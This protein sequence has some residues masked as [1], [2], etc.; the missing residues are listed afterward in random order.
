MLEKEKNKAI[1]RKYKIKEGMLNIFFSK[2]TKNLKLYK[3][4]LDNNLKTLKKINTTF[5]R[6]CIELK[7]N[8]KTV[9]PAFEWQK[10]IVSLNNIFAMMLG[11]IDARYDHYKRDFEF[12]KTF[13]DVEEM[14][15]ITLKQKKLSEYRS[16]I[17]QDYQTLFKREDMQIIK[18]TIMYN[19]SYK[20]FDNLFKDMQENSY[21]LAIQGQLIS[22]YMFGYNNSLFIRPEDIIPYYNKIIGEYKLDVSKNNYNCQKVNNYKK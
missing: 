19:P 8:K 16:E 2:K 4:F 6:S 9:Y 17:I 12:Q 15:D 5:T 11:I 21:S 1:L 13:N 14:R 22:A 18:E 20:N 7:L 3:E 10:E